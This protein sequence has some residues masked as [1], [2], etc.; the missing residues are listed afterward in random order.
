MKQEEIIT[1][2]IV[3]LCFLSSM[4]SLI[5]ISMYFKLEIANHT[6]GFQLFITNIIICVGFTFLGVPIAK[7]VNKFIEAKA[8]K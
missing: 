3:V 4:W 8:K 5:L 7:E 1:T 2:I 6:Y